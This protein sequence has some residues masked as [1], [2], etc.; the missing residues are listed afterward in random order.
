MM[1]LVRHNA[2]EPTVRWFSYMQASS[3]LLNTAHGG[4]GTLDSAL[5]KADFAFD[6]QGE[7]YLLVNFILGCI[8]QVTDRRLPPSQ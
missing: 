4:I 8:A 6:E 3:P 1:E 7:T 5:Q 2:F